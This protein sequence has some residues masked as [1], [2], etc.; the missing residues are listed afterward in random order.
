VTEKQKRKRVL[1]ATDLVPRPSDFAVGSPK[2]RAAAR[3]LLE[4]RRKRRRPPE[5]VLDLSSASIEHCREIYRKIVELRRL[6]PERDGDEPYIELAFPKDFTPDA[7]E[8]DET[9]LT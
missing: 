1:P 2:S 7:Q 4:S 5:Y 9:A 3:A 8:S 6:H